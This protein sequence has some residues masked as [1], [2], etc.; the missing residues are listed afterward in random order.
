[1]SASSPSA[2]GGIARRALTAGGNVYL[3]AST[4]RISSM[5]V[6]AWLGEHRRRR[7]GGNVYLLAATQGISSSMRAASMTRRA[8][9]TACAGGNVYPL[10]TTHRINSSMRAAA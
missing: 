9:T 1:M 3:L 6:A 7:A 10:A 4:H 5:R 2:H 8:S